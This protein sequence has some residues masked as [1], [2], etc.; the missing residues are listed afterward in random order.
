M[1]SLFKNFIIIIIIIII[2][3]LIVSVFNIAEYVFPGPIGVLQI[4]IERANDILDAA[5]ITTIEAISG[6]LIA[7]II[8]TIIS[9]FFMLYPS[10]EKLLSN[11]L[12]ALQSTPIM[13]IAP[14]LTLWFGTGIGSKIASACI[15]CFF[16]MLSGWLS[17]IKSVSYEEKDLF[18][19]MNATKTQTIY[20]LIIPRSLPFFFSS[21]KI[22]APL[23]FVGA[24]VG[25]FVGASSGIGFQILSSS[26]YVKTKDMFCFV[27][28]ASFLGILFYKLVVL[29]EN[30]LLFWHGSIQK[31]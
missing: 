23:S 12:I 10:L 19:I 5:T 1:R 22:S 30:K 29:L 13:A 11:F 21:L 25:E 9:L 14:L 17:G 4:A 3:Q 27:I 15:V 8:T 20:Y 18:K 16:P 28:V 7:I 6:L 26:Y 24:I 31:K 2:W